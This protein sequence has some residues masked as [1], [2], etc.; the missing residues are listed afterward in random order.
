MT[1]TMRAVLLPK[2]HDSGD[3]S[4]PDTKSI[5]LLTPSKP[6]LRKSP[7][8]SLHPAERVAS[9]GTPEWGE[10]IS[11]G[12]SEAQPPVRPENMTAPRQGCG[13]TLQ[14]PCRGSSILGAVPP[15]AALRLPGANLLVPLQGAAALPFA[16]PAILTA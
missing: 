6:R 15:R 13:T 7:G 5:D 9:G 3:H 2:L 1:S 8:V 4:S 16:C 10:E 11:R 14:R 12:W